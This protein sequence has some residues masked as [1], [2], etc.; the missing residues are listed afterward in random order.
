[1]VIEVEV[2]VGF[3]PPG[4]VVVLHCPASEDREAIQQ[5]LLD[6][7]AH[8]AEV[9]W[10]GGPD[11]RIDHHQ[12]VRPVHLQPEGILDP[13]SA[14]IVHRYLRLCWVV[15]WADW[16]PGLGDLTPFLPI[17]SPPAGVCPDPPQI[18]AKR[19]ANPRSGR[20]A[21]VSSPGGAAITD[22]IAFRA[23]IPVTVMPI[24]AN[25]AGSDRSTPAFGKIMCLL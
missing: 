18:Y 17:G 25:E 15:S 12:V 1:M 22:L 7:V 20:S 8:L 5:S 16:F 2:L 6:H 23:G 24:E 21:L 4:A 19:P 3:P 11:H 14:S 9:Q 13:E 10:F